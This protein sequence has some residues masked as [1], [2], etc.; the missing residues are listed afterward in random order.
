[1]NLDLETAQLLRDSAQR[2]ADD[3]YGFL[4]RHAVLGDPA[5]F[6]ARAWRD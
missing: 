3:H 6:S 5:G 2:Y 4:Q 1:M